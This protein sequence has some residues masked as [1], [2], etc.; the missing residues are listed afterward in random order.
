MAMWLCE[1][2]RDRWR[3]DGRMSRSMAKAESA[4]QRVLF[5]LLGVNRA[6]KFLYLALKHGARER[7]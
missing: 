5:M 4:V 2:L 3:S 7:P 6:G 1:I